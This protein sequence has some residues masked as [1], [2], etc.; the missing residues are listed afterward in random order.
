MH[1]FTGRHILGE[2]YGVSFEKVNNLDF[3]ENLLRR[4][5]EAA[6]ATICGTIVKKFKPQG[7]SILI[8]LSESHVSVHTYP[9]KE[10]IFFDIFTCGIKCKPYKF[11]EVIENELKPS[12][13]NI[14]VVER[15]N[16]NA[17]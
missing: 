12:E 7:L 13:K 10:S 17:T 2:L 15:G 1:E 11:V 14:K 8:L 6:N 4:G 9:E 5:A 16:K 3:M